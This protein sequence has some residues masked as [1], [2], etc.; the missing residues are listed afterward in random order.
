MGSY[1]LLST[2]YFLLISNCLKQAST[3]YWKLEYYSEL[4]TKTGLIIIGDGKG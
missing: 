3:L 2:F 1:F 4:Y